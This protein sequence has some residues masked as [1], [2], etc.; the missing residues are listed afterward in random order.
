M[1]ERLE[2]HIVSD[3]TGDTGAR[4][5]RAAQSQFDDTEIEMVRH[6]RVQTRDQL[7]RALESASGRRAAVFYTLV[8]AGLREAVVELAREHNLVVQDVLGPALNAVAT[9]SG[10][11]ATMVPGRTAPLDAQ[12]FRRIAA[13]EFAVKHDDGRGADDLSQADVVLIGVSRT[14]KTPTCIYLANRG[15]KA[16]NIPFVPG[17]PLPPELLDAQRPL[18][19]GLTNDPERLIQV[20]RNRLS[21]LH[22]DEQ[23]DYTDLEAVR[24]EVAQARRLFAE[25]HWPVIDVTRRSIEET[26]AAIMKL[27]AR[28]QGLEA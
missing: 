5:A 9:A 15:I 24:T 19:V 11:E 25:R 18:I 8:D 2:I 26:A 20:R 27:L 17:V 4:V 10:R 7:A 12:Y 28:R 22:H 14:S 13:I 1:G 3:S 6:A 23:T 21:S 16:A